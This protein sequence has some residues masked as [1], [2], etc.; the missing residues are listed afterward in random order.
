MFSMTL[1][2]NLKIYDDEKASLFEIQ[3]VKID[4][5]SISFLTGLKKHTV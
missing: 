4:L 1:Y 3:G 5:K 2:E